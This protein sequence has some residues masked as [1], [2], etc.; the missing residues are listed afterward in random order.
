[1]LIRVREWAIAALVRAEIVA[2]VTV[3]VMLF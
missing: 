2:V 3:D 1:M